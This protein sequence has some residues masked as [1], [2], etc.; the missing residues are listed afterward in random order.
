[1]SLNPN[2]LTWKWNKITRAFQGSGEDGVRTQ[3]RGAQL[4]PG[5]QRAT[6][7]EIIR[8]LPLQTSLVALQ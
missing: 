2:S 1:M 7:E 5:L 3:T 4:G 6:T 8:K